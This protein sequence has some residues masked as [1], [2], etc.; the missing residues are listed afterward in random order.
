MEEILISILIYL[1]IVILLIVLISYLKI[2]RRRVDLLVI[3]ECLNE[4]NASL[5]TDEEDKEFLILMEEKF[6]WYTKTWTLNLTPL[7]MKRYKKVK[8]IIKKYDL[9]ITTLD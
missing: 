8:A 7:Y 4:E 5:I 3:R 1:F 9:K 2:F 6:T